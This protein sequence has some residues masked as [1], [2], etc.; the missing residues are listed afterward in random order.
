MDE[1]L[2]PDA[3]R[4]SDDARSAGRAL[5]YGVIGTGMMGCEHIRNIGAL[6]GARVSAIA[7]PDER[8]R[9]FGILSC[10]EISDEEVLV[11]EDPAEML[12]EAPID[13]IVIASPNMTH[14]NV[15][16]DVWAT[17]L[18]V[19]LEKPMC[20]TL[21]D[22]RRVRE[23]AAVHRGV[24]W[25]GLE[26]RYMATVAAF[27]AQ[28]RAGA[29]GRL[30][31]LFIREHRHPFLPKVGDWN[32]FSRNTGGTLVEKCCHF[33]DLMNLAIE[34]DPVRVFAS[35]GQD[36]N[37][38]DE[39]Y[40][41]ETPDILDNAFV[42]VDYANGARA[43]LDLCMF[44]ESSRFEQEL[45]ATG[46]GGKLACTV[47]GDELVVGTRKWKDH[48]AQPIP[49]DPRVQHI[50]FHHGASYLEHLDFMAAIA[51]GQRAKVSADDGLRSVAIGLAA[52]RSIEC[53]APVSLEELGGL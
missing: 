3:S 18:H 31:M 20:T 34:A 26:Y 10:R 16:E 12:R 53:G 43:C 22:C 28:L 29:V 8:S 32:R 1:P 24:F 48:R 19:L 14:A 49:V 36:V 47:P 52:H 15:L 6:P 27:L 13:A 39:R 42:I 7:D 11:Y 46:D 5:R 44:A 2:R 4:H 50:G 37:H 23:R 9:G 51:N 41:G 45:M 21:E 33:F 38:L 17:D 35:G 40:E 30:H 25:V